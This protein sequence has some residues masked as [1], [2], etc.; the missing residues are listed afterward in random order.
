MAIQACLAVG[1]EYRVERGS[2][3]GQRRLQLA[4]LSLFIRQPGELPMDIGWEGKPL[5]SRDGIAQYFQDYLL[6]E[7]I[8]PN[9]QYTY[10]RRIVP[11]LHEIIKMLMSTPHTNQACISVAKP[12]DVLLEDPPCLRSLAWNIVDGKLQMTS[13]WRSWD[14]Y[15]GLPT[16][17]GG[18]QLLNE[19]VSGFA[20]I[21][22]GPQW[23]VSNGAHL[24]EYCWEAFGREL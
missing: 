12:D 6:S 18:L 1:H 16:N 10:G 14:L 3:E 22:A 8:R 2:Y 23:A 15:T 24:Y 13:Y 11:R 20:D 4:Q 19:Y 9:E 5:S 17:L 7:E 21:P